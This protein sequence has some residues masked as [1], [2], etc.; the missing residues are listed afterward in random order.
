M[1]KKIKPTDNLSNKQ[2]H[3]SVHSKIVALNEDELARDK[4]FITTNGVVELY[5]NPDATS[6]G[7]IVEVSISSGTILEA[8]ERYTDTEG[9]FDY[10]ESCSKSTLC[11]ID[12]PE[13]KDSFRTFLSAVPD[14][15]GVSDSTMLSLIMLARQQMKK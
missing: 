7:Q 8:A 3:R 14:Y 13:F 12:T 5:Y 9:F 11:D 10:L 6:G 4:F 2:L 15:E 1:P